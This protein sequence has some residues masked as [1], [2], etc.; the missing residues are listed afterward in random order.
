MFEKCL[1]LNQAFVP[2]PANKGLS[3][4]PAIGARE[5][6]DTQR[7]E[8]EGE[9]RPFRPFAG[10]FSPGVGFSTLCSTRD[11]SLFALTAL[12]ST[13]SALLLVPQ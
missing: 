4:S 1:Q 12:Y 8:G 13:E 2:Y 3:G 11:L 10:S 5:D 6:I 9:K 7:E